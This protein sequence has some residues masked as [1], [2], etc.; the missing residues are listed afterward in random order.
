[1]GCDIHAF[2]EIRQPDRS[3]KRCGDVFPYPESDRAWRKQTHG[4]QPF[5]WR[6]YGVFGFLADVRNY[7]AVPCIAKPRGL[8]HD[9]SP[10]V[11]AEYETWDVDAHSLSWLSLRELAEFD[12]DAPV[13][14]RRITRQE[15][16][17]FFNGG[18]T[19]TAAEEALATKTTFREFLGDF[20]MRDV[21]I[22]KTLGPLDDVRIVFWFDN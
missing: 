18:A 9:L 3:W 13:I 2:A 7:S 20:F 14:D 21:D 5:D 17:N 19:A 22:L 6:S 10:E 11:N 4:C 16:P 12:Y 1:M 8:P 15:G